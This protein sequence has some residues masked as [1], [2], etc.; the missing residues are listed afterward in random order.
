MSKINQMQNA[1]KELEGDIFQ[2]LC[3]AYLNAGELYE[4]N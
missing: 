1:L 4:R 2:K 3:D